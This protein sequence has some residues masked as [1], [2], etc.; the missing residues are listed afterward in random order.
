MKQIIFAFILLFSPLAFAKFGDD[1]MVYAHLTFTEGGFG[2]GADYENEFSRSF[3]LGGYARLYAKDDDDKIRAHGVNTF[4]AFV[5]PHFYR[6]N[7]DLYVGAG[8]GIAQV[9][10]ADASGGRDDETAIGPNFHIGLQYKMTR[11]M[12]IGVENFKVYGW[13]AGDFKGLLVDSTAVTGRY[14]F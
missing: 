3:G 5:R 1:H 8:V 7:W 13:F 14:N 12:S 10:S 6:K 9:D 2:L 11:E 4:G